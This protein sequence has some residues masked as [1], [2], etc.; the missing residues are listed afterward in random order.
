M[1]LVP[2]KLTARL[3]GMAG[4]LQ[5]FALSSQMAVS[6]PLEYSE[7][8]RGLRWL[9]PHVK[10]P[11]KHMRRFLTIHWNKKAPD[12]LYIVSK[13][14]A[15]AAEKVRGRRLGANASIYGPAFLPSEYK[16]YFFLKEFDSS[17]ANTTI[18]ADHYNGWHDFASNMFWLGVIIGVLVLLHFLALALLKWRL[19]SAARGALVFPRFELFLAIYALP[20]FCQALAF[21]IRGGTTTGIIVGVILLALPA[22]FL[23]SVILFLGVALFLGR[24]VQYN[25]VR[26]L[27]NHE[28]WYKRASL[29][30]PSNKSIGSWMC[31]RGLPSTFLARFGLI[32][33]DHKGPPHVVTVDNMSSKSLSKWGESSSNGIGRMKASNS[34]DESDDVVI[35]KDGRMFGV[36]QASY[37]VVDMV[38][39]ALLGIVFGAYNQTDLSW[40]QVSIVLGSTVVQLLYLIAFTPYISKGLQAVEIVSLLSETVLFALGLVLLAFASPT[41][42]NQA[43]GRAMLALLLLTLVVQLSNEWHALMK[44]LLKLSPSQSSS[45]KQGLKMLLWGLLLPLTTEN[46]RSKLMSSLH[47]QPNTGLV[48]VVPVTQEEDM[49][50]PGETPMFEAKDLAYGTKSASLEETG[51]GESMTDCNVEGQYWSEWNVPQAAQGKRSRG[52]AT[53]SEMKTL[54]ELAKASFPQESSEAGGRPLEPQSSS[55]ASPSSLIVEHPT[56]SRSRPAFH[57]AG[58]SSEGSSS[59]DAEIVER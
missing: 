41:Q 26:F 13:L 30:M 54:R 33:E 25:E 51:S 58:I 40:S 59:A 4:H 37:T 8:T 56:P 29:C 6:L 21:I 34:N 50:S 18:M 5:V 9:I 17:F 31:K 14:N 52:T 49:T 35:S 28:S 7:T 24:F 23:M 55:L 22:G 36:A 1:L 15:Q 10:L 57:T 47:G 39:R 3:Q 12:Q 46:R 11:W 19:R 53:S 42:D 44:Q 45:F 48:T 27:A 38:R 2:S 32:F 43:I 16:Q 20:G